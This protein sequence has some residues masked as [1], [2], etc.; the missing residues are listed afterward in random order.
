MDTLAAAH[1][2]EY[3]TVLQGKVPGAAARHAAS[4][5]VERM[6]LLHE[7]H[8]GHAVNDRDTKSCHKLLK[9][10]ISPRRPDAETT[11]DKRS[12]RAE[13]YFKD[14]CDGLIRN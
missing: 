4:S 1:R 3:I 10:I 12:L 2:Q 6:I 5:G 13:K 11:E 14:L 9:K 7:I 8:A